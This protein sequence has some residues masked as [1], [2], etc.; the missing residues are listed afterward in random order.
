V[1]PG[2]GF[3]GIADGCRLHAVDQLRSRDER[4]AKAGQRQQDASIAWIILHVVGTALDRADGDGIGHEIRL[5]PRL[6]DEKSGEALQ[7]GTNR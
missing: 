2:H 1:S 6:D 7:H 5:E 4:N 3:W